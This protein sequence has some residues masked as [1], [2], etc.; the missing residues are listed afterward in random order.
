LLWLPL[1]EPQTHRRCHKSHNFFGQSPHLWGF[2][3]LLFR[4][5]FQNLMLEGLLAP[6]CLGTPKGVI[7]E[8]S[9]PLDSKEWK[10]TCS[11]DSTISS[12]IFFLPLL[13]LKNRGSFH[14]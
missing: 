3:L 8:L 14:W 6:F 4:R 11:F 5:F 2:L 13:L 7:K 10:S 1:V 9:S 12:R